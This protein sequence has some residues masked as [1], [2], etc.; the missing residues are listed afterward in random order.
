MKD[1]RVY[2]INDRVEYR[3]RDFNGTPRQCFGYVK[4]VR[5]T[6]FGYYRYWIVRSHCCTT[7]DKGLGC[8]DSVCEDAI[9][10]DVP[11]FAKAET[12]KTRKGSRDEYSK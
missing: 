3:G 1:R 8:I 5:K 10:G 2:S 6:L 9:F 7:G 11:D 12:H 4:R